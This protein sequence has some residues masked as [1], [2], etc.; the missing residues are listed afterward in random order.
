MSIENGRTAHGIMRLI[1]QCFHTKLH[2]CT[3]EENLKASSLKPQ[4]QTI[5]TPQRSSAAAETGLMH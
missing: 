3:S 5:E 1:H 4:D 2:K